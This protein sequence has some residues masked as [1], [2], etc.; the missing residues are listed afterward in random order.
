MSSANTKKKQLIRPF[1]GEFG[2]G[3]RDITPPIGINNKNW[4]ASSQATATGIHQPLLVTCI[5]IETKSNPSPMVF[6][7]ADLGWWKNMEDE[8][9]VRN[10]ILEKTGLEEASLLFCFSHTHA[11]PNLN[12]GDKDKLGGELIAPYLDTLRET[13]T[14]LIKECLRNKVSGI[15]AWEYGTCNL[16]KNRDYYEPE[17][18]QYF[19]G[20]NSSKPA[21]DTLLVGRI[22]DTAGGIMGT[23]VNYAC[24]PTTLAW[25]NLK[26]SPDF[27]GTFKKVMKENTGAP[28]LFIQGASGDLAPA[29][30]YSGNVA[31]AEKHGR[32]LAFSALA[33][34]ES[35][36]APGEALFF[37]E[38]V[39]SGAPLSIWKSKPIPAASKMSAEMITIVLPLKPWP[40]I[41]EL[42]QSINECEDPVLK[43]RLIRKLGVRR[44]IGDG[45]TV[46]VKVWYWQLGDC[47]FVGQPNEAYSVFQ[48]TIRKQFSPLPVVVGNIVN[49]HI[50]YLPPKEYYDK[51][52][53][54]VWQTPFEAGAY[55]VLVQEV[56]NKMKSKF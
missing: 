45:N 56:L 36:S 2:I 28:S 30:Q 15:L 21:D 53:Y 20:Y 11:G 22:T 42:K 32:Q 40:S 54:T 6:L 24:H 18:N 46:T 55:E 19:V 9:Y 12:R 43:E 50:G 51:D 14:E 35:M 13:C 23:I 16:A 33:V 44:S 10:F 1:E 5:S 39:A 38:T 8:A 49:G 29:E 27:P 34:L 25:D 41:R 37:K 31:L 26:I 52:M 48:Q 17:S 4:G 47:L 3:Q 7:S